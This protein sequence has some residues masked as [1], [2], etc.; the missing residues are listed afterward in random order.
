MAK[1]CYY[2]ILQVQ[3]TASADEL[4]K[5]FRSLAMK[6]HPDRNPGNAEAEAKFKEASEAYEVLSDPQKRQLYDQYG[7]AAFEGGIGGGGGGGGGFGGVNLED[8]FGDLFGS[9]FGG[10]SSGGRRKPQGPR[11]GD[12][13]QMVVDIDLVEA[14]KGTKKTVSVKRE[15]N[16]ETCKGTG[17]KPG[18]QPVSCKRCGGQGVVIQRQGFFQVQSACPSCNGR[19]QI[20]SDPCSG[21]RGMGRVVG[22]TSME[23]EI[24]PGV[25]TGDR[26]RYSG[27]GN[28]GE[29]N[30]T[31]GHLDFVIRVKEHKF[32]QRDGANLICQ[33][34]ITFSQAALGGQ[35][36]L[37]GLTG[38]KIPLDL[39]RGIQTHE[40]LRVPGRGMPRRRGGNDRGELIVQVVV[41][42]PSGLTAEQEELF[43]RL[44][45]LEKKQA[46]VNAPGKKSFFGKLKDWL[47]EDAK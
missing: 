47:T 27:E 19:G 22:R 35:I 33:W 34:P 39:P 29:A 5:A 3:K 41:D 45:E 7:H 43:R 44:A 14:A 40:V 20:L 32:F 15:D 26:M 24:P 6:H 21:C 9:F 16:C 23:V 17:A 10:G 36:E 18:S 2:E 42:T 30:A 1:V 11:P 8:I 25:D 12:D 37:T 4:K 46:K 31:R 13:I 38:E 28:A